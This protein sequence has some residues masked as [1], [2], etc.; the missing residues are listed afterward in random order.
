M[1]SSP[2]Q[3]N[4]QL[5]SPP[6]ENIRPSPAST[7]TRTAGSAPKPSTASRIA[8]AASASSAFMSSGRLSR[9]VA[10]PSSIVVRIAPVISR[11]HPEQAELGLAD[12]LVHRRRQRQRQGQARVGRIENAVVT[13][14]RG[15]VVWMA[16]AL[17]GLADRFL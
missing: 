16:L 12:R 15:G 14:A 10:T 2:G 7:I 17:V 1:A 9:R 13:D 6:A 4:T 5:K 8:R 11:S 3:V